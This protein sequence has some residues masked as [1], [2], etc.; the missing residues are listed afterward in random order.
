MQAPTDF[1]HRHRP[2][3]SSYPNRPSRAPRR[4]TPSNSHSSPQAFSL[5]DEAEIGSDSPPA[6]YRSYCGTLCRISRL[7]TEVLLSGLDTLEML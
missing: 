1:C 7:A 2:L 3:S 5:Q 4:R 6:C